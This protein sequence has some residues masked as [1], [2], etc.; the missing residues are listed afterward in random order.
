[1]SLFEKVAWFNSISL[2]IGA[3]FYAIALKST[4][5]TLDFGIGFVV[6]VSSGI[7]LILCNFA[8]IIFSESEGVSDR[9]S[10]GGRAE[11]TTRFR[12]DLHLFYW[13]I[14]CAIL[15]GTG[16]WLAFSI[17]GGLSGKANAMAAILGLGLF[18]LFIALFLLYKK[19]KGE[20]VAGGDEYS[21]GEILLQKGLPGHDERDLLIRKSSRRHSL[22]ILFTV[23]AALFVVGVVFRT[24]F[25]SGESSFPLDSAYLPL[26]FAVVMYFRHLIIQVSTIIQYRMGR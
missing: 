2:T 14:L 5:G 22:A 13:G 23:L 20:F 11:V 4:A 1:M 15:I 26:L 7:L 17:G 18:F 9:V 12:T 6:L 3:I 16:Y 10:S 19:R 24:H 8:W 25:N 21:S